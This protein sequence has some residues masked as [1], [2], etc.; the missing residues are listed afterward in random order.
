MNIDDKAN[1]LL[2]TLLDK[3]QAELDQDIPLDPQMGALA[4]G[5][6]KDIKLIKKKAEDEDDMTLINLLNDMP[7]TSRK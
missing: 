7:F 1:K 3:I 4:R 2:L 5:L 6:I